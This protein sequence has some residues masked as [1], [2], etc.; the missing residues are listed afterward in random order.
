MGIYLHLQVKIGYSHTEAHSPQSKN[1]TCG[2]QMDTIRNRNDVPYKHKCGQKNRS[3][4]TDLFSL[5]RIIY[6]QANIVRLWRALSDLSIW[7]NINHL[8]PYIPCRV[9]VWF[10]H[11]IVHFVGM[12][13][14]SFQFH[15]RS[16]EHV[17]DNIFC[18]FATQHCIM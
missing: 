3:M 17:R 13:D 8:K 14:F 6:T 12:Y 16:L 15:N 5:Q 4:W 11:R 10:V 18:D 9:F 7:T 1:F 2:G